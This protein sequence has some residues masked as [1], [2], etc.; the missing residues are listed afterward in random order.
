M[1]SEDKSSSFTK[2][3]PFDRKNDDIWRQRIKIIM[4]LH[5]VDD[6][7]VENISDEPTRNYMK[8]NAKDMALFTQNLSDSHFSY[9]ADETCARL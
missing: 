5:E 4:S 1:A 7:I 9:R 8:K 6:I 2:I 3:T